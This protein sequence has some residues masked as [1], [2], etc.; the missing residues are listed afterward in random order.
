M[1]DETLQKTKRALNNVRDLQLCMV[2]DIGGM[3]IVDQQLTDFVMVEFLC[4]RTMI[5]EDLLRN[6]RSYHS[7]IEDAVRVLEDDL[8]G[9][10]ELSVSPAVVQRVKSS[11]RRFSNNCAVYRLLPEAEFDCTRLEVDEFLMSRLRQTI[12]QQG[13]KTLVG[14]LAERVR[15]SQGRIWELMESPEMSDPEVAGRVSTAISATQPYLSI[16]LGGSFE[17]LLG[18]LGLNLADD[19]PPPLSQRE[20]YIRRFGEA[21][22]KLFKD[23]GMD[24]DEDWIDQV[25]RNW[26]H[27]DEF[28]KR[29]ASKAPAGAEG[30]FLPELLQFLDRLHEREMENLEQDLEFGEPKGAEV[31]ESFKEEEVP[32]P[33]NLLEQMLRLV[34]QTVRAR[35]GPT[36]GGGAEEPDIPDDPGDGDPLKGGYG[37]DEFTRRKWGSRRSWCSRGGLR[38]APRPAG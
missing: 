29:Y 14:K 35:S 20:G 22:T 1:S 32:H 26:H 31:W 6:V 38:R 28:K 23:K 7:K 16:T 2:F 15:L 19:S 9:Y 21:L 5:G 25:V 27:R 4:L 34:Q 37:G 17:G 36:P 33:R 3:K 8:T 13:S 10:L 24:Y 12:S 11:V 30:P 18:Q